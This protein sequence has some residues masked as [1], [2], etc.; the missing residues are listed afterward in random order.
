V[1]ESLQT[2]PDILRVHNL[3]TDAKEPAQ[4]A[5]QTTIRHPSRGWV[6]AKKG[7]E[8]FHLEMP[9]FAGMTH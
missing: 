6:S 3:L 7:S 4:G 5:N 1:I 8:P 2:N 9:A